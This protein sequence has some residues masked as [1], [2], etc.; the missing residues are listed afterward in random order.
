MG[1]LY[2]PALAPTF[3]IG[4]GSHGG[5][6][7]SENVGIKHL[8]NY[9]TVVVRR[10]N[11]MWLKAPPKMFFNYGCL[12]AALKEL[13]K[14]KRAFIVT[15]KILFDMGF[16]DWITKPLEANGT[17]TALFYDV[18]PDPDLHCVAKCQ[19]IAEEFKPDVF[20][21]LGGGSSI[22]IMKLCRMQY[23]CGTIDFNALS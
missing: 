6:S 12:N 1:D 14:Y 7:T 2:S 23:D 9:K 19:K 8:L 18:V 16:A 4:C 20:I 15:D 10:E 22:D 5:N 21:A 11:P 17:K 13:N 3:S